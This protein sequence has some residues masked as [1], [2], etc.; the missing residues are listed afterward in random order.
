VAHRPITIAKRL[1][2]NRPVRFVIVGGISIATNLAVLRFVHGA[3]HVEITAASTIS[4]IAS[5]VVN[6][7]LNR[8]WTFE[9][10]DGPV[11]GHLWRYLTLA[12]LNLVLNA[13]METSLVVL[14]VPYLLAQACT[15]GTLAVLNFVV[16]SRWIFTTKT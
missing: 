4:F 10:S 11:F 8:V 2:R 9:S 14:G 7:G 3:L 16:S 13:V 5:F 15:T 1:G 6:F 12:L